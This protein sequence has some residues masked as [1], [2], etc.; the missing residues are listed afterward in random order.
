MS[1][2]TQLGKPGNCSG[3]RVSTVLSAFIECL[4]CARDSEKKAEIKEKL[5]V[6]C[7]RRSQS[8]AR[9]QE[10]MEYTLG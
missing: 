6:L 1:N 7:C 2:F 10:Q 3:D 4:L 8:M 9:I 5:N